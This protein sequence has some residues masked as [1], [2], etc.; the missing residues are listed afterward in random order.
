MGWSRKAA[1]ACGA[2]C[3]ATLVRY[4]LRGLRGHIDGR[5]L[6]HGHKVASGDEVLRSAQDDRA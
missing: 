2:C 5:T 4:R 3:N 6:R 1:V